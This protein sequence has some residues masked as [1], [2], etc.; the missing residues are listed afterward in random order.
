MAT[1]TD[2]SEEEVC[3]D[4]VVRVVGNRYGA[5]WQPVPSSSGG[6]RSNVVVAD[7]SRLKEGRDWNWKDHE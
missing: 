4:G 2:W 1:N 3:F 6:D 5:W 7:K